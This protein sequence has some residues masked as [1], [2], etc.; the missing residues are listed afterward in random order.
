MELFVRHH[1]DREKNGKKGGEY[2][3]KIG[4]I[5]QNSRAETNDEVPFHVL[6]KQCIYHCLVCVYIISISSATINEVP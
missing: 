5:I 6:P 3:L 2:M 4:S 1:F